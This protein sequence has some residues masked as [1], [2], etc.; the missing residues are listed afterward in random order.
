M[1]EDFNFEAFSVNVDSDCI[2]K[3]FDNYDLYGEII[4]NDNHENYGDDIKFE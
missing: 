3:D 2:T 4:E 1:K